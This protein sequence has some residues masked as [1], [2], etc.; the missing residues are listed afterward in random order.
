MALRPLSLNELDFVTGG[1]GACP[2]GT[3]CASDPQGRS[4]YGGGSCI[5][6]IQAGVSLGVDFATATKNLPL[7][8]AAIAI[9]AA[10]G[11]AA[12]GCFSGRGYGH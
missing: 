5:Q 6:S 12:G 10:A 11:A 3:C 1:G 2:A 4:G 8:I 7:G 9:G